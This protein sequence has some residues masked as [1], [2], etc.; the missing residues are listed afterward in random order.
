MVCVV[1]Q[2]WEET[3]P[4][5]SLAS[6]RVFKINS[7]SSLDKSEYRKC[8]ALLP[9]EKK[10]EEIEIKRMFKTVIFSWQFS[11]VEFKEH[12]NKDYKLEGYFL[13]IIN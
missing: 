12:I 13:N 6:S 2:I 1:Y 4:P 10:E 8:I 9:G 11:P 3:P 5:T 7:G